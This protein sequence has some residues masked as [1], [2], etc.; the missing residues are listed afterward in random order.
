MQDFSIHARPENCALPLGFTSNSPE[1][2]FAV[3]HIKGAVSAT[4]VVEGPFPPFR[5]YDQ[6]LQGQ[7]LRR[8]G[9]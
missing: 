2:A 4:R 8:G 3:L 5:I 1:A 9:S 6:G 7:G